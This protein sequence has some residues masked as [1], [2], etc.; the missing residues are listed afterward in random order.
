MNRSMSA[1]FETRVRTSDWLHEAGQR[2]GNQAQTANQNARRDAGPW[3]RTVR[4]LAAM[5]GL[6]DGW[7]GFD[8]K[9]PSRE[10]LESAIGLA[11]VWCDK[12]MSPPARVV[13][14]LDGCV[15]FEWQFSDGTYADVE[16]DRPFHAEVTVIEPGHPPRQWALP[17]E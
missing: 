4:E 1:V 5:Q 17:T 2:N 16:V 11:Y 14:S 6:Q 10:L 3:E 13:P 9:A 15:L 7:D 8:A 12:G